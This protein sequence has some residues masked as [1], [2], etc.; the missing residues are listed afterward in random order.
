MISNRT[1]PVKR[2][3][4]NTIF[5]DIGN[6]L[7]FFSHE[8][9]FSQLSACTGI[10]IDDLKYK[11]VHENLGIL[12]ESGQITTEEL[13]QTLKRAGSKIFSIEEM[14]HAL[15]DIFTPNYDLWPIVEKLKQTGSKLVLISNTNE[16][17]FEHLLSHYSILQHF[18]AFILSHKVGAC[19]PD[20]QDL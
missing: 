15:A 6:V 17:H 11:T 7:V 13:Y 12:Y 8:Q 3:K 20:P 10:S 5:F 1:N 16:C 14:K 2:R 18:D 9:M 19:K 4:P